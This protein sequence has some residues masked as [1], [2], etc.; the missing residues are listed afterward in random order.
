LPK[1]KVLYISQATGGVQRHVIDLV[2][3]IDKSR[4]ETAAICPPRDLIKG[5]SLDKESFPEAFKRAGV[6]VYPVTMR[7]KINPV[8]DLAALWR[9]YA[10]L[11]KER[12]DVV[13][14]HSSKAGFL[15][16]LAA[17]MAGV[18]AIVHTPHNFAFDRPR[19]MT[20]SIAFF[21][22]LEKFAGF[23]CDRVFAVCRDEQELAVSLG[24]LPAEKI[25]LI[26]NS[27]DAPRLDQ[28]VNSETKRTELGI[29]QGE[30]LIVSVGRL[31]AQKSPKDFVRAADIVLHKMPDARFLFL[32]DG[33]LFK[34]IDRLIRKKNLESRVK[35]LGWRNDTA[36]VIAASDIFVLSSLWEVLPNYSLLDA[37]GL[38]KPVVITA[39]S[40][41]GDMV[42]NGFNGYVV[43]VADP[44]A[45]AEAILKLLKLP[46]AG[47]KTMG[48]NSREVF[49]KRPSPD[50]IV[51]MI[52][53]TYIGILYR[54]GALHE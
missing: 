42:K 18:P 36:E 49:D 54:K 19:R 9:I 12:F 30:R 16:R 37:M 11:K 10:F 23:F 13:H 33:P 48:K 40:G 52:E 50:E 43:P 6:R 45:M 38:G 44:E 7:R 20:W 32:G 28:G 41:S 3:R 15:G 31:A 17:R 1:I 27:I 35:I 34:E 21:G 4:F 39:T 5:V 22:L 51:K 46:P 24:V 47:L 26:S 2:L 8:S 25:T 29:R 53:D 14:T